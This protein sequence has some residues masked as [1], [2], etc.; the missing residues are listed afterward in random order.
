VRIA[1]L[2]LAEPATP[3]L[4]DEVASRQAMID[5]PGAGPAQRAGREAGSVL[6]R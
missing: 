4:V 2:V 5:D 6:E 1:H 3:E